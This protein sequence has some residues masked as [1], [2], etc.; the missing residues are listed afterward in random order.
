VGGHAWTADD[1]SQLEAL[2]SAGWTNDEIAARLGRTSP[3]IGVRINRRGLANKRG[4]GGRTRTG[5]RAALRDQLKDGQWHS[6]HEL[7]AIVGGVIQPE[8][9]MREARPGHDYD[10]WVYAGRCAKV[11]SALSTLDVERRGRRG[12]KEYRLCP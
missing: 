8:R 11:A 12:N 9:A 3:S 10:E 2:V 1:E 5:L 7:V 6:I 4:P